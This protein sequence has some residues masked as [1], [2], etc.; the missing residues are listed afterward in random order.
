M[1]HPLPGQPA[2]TL[3]MQTLSGEA[4]QLHAQSDA[5]FTL[6]VFYRGLHC[7]LCRKQLT[8]LQ[9]SL[10]EF[11]QRN[12]AVIAASTDTED[13]AQESKSEWKIDQLNIGYGLTIEQARSWGLYISSAI[14]DAEPSFFAEPGLFLVAGDGTL[15]MASIQSMPFARPQFD[16]LLSAIDFITENDY[17]PRGTV[18]SN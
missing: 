8:T 14:K 15:Y 13:K 4:F 5:R 7:P 1:T 9:R 6:I 10:G 3:S 17:P 18:A 2:P 11:E 16:D 12:V